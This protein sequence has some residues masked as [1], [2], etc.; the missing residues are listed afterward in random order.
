MPFYGVITFI[1]YTILVPLQNLWFNRQQTWSFISEGVFLFSYLILVLI[2][3][4]LYYIS[5]IINGDYSFT[6]Y[7]L[8]VYFPISFILLPVL[9]VLRW[10]FFKK[11][12]TILTEKIRLLGENKLDSLFISIAELVAVSSADNYVEV[13]YLIDGALQKK[14]LRNTLKNISTQV[15]ALRQTHRSHLINP[16]HLVEWKDSKTIL[17]NQL[18]IPVTKTYKDSILELQIRP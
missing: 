14:L 1:G 4:Y 8:G 9:I 7:V 3:C 12:P 16:Q 15:P 2:G 17:V 18:E 10:F 5:D 13:S 11:N 6:K